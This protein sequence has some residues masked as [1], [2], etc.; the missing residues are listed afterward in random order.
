MR[1]T[2]YKSL[3]L[4]GIIFCMAAV[5][6]LRSL[7]EVLGECTIS[8]LFG[9]VNNS[10]WEKMKPI[11]LIYLLYGLVQLMCARP[12][13]RRF[14][15]A[16]ALSLYIILLIYILLSRITPDEYNACVT[17][18]ALS[19]GFILC[20][21]LTLNVEKTAELFPA[22]CFMLLLIFVM[23]FSFTAFPPKLDIF[24]DRES[25]MYGIIPNYID[26]GAVNLS[27]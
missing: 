20:E 16:K 24:L 21:Y 10:I 25:G 17:L 7:S 5:H 8:I 13:F 9:S 4:S 6:L 26:I 14:V 1:K 11:I 23:Y 18:A 3:E 19:A 12:Y 22:A 2:L 15:S 27:N